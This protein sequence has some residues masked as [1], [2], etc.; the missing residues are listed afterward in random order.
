MKKIIKWLSSSM[1]VPPLS[2]GCKLCARGEKLV[3]LVTGKCNAK[4]FYC[5]L[6]FKKQG[7]DRIFANEWELD[8]EDDIDKI[9]TEAQLIGAKGAGITGGD[10]LIVL[11]RTCRYISLLKNEFGENFHI[12][13]YTANI[14]NFEEIEKLASA[15]LDELRIHPVPHLWKDMK[16]SNLSKKIHY[17]KNE[18]IDVA[19]EIPV[20]PD[21]EKDIL[22]LIKWADS[23]NV[24]WVNLNELE[25]SESNCEKLDERG[26]SLK[27][28]ASASVAG[29]EEV[30]I[31]ILKK[32][33]ELD[34]NIGVHYCSSSFKDSIQLKNRI[35]RRAKSI[36]RPYDVITEDGTIL[37]GAIYT[38]KSLK[39]TE[40]F[41]RTT[42][43]IPKMLI[44][45]DEEKRRINI[46]AWVLQEI[47]ENLKRQ[48]F[49]CYMVEEYPTADRLEVERIDLPI[50][51]T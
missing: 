27:D 37:R 26:Y 4:C 28:E 24:D 22:S 31:K 47:A 39:E 51:E 2:P 44:E 21:R 49:K 25:Y 18:N 33:G 13:L 10:P 5:P 32:C 11:D 46:A 34:L 45:I 43:N 12:H 9:L 1:Y 36:A 6:S 20:L 14:K 48:G 40:K 23:N 50:K 38:K 41:I 3:L 15:G 42:Y 29:S 35:K 8:N 7:K 30:A 16:R 17:L 19:I